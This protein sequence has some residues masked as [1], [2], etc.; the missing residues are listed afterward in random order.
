MTIHHI[1]IDSS[2]EVIFCY[3]YNSSDIE[4]MVSLME[5][6][7]LPISKINDAISTLMKMNTG[8]TI[9]RDDMKQSLVFVS[10]ATSIEQFSDT[11]AHEM[12]HVATAIIDYYNVYYDSEDAAW[13]HGYLTRMVTKRLKN[14][15]CLVLFK[16]FDN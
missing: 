14:N 6:F 3:G 1:D 15:F 12:N 4:A 7:G 11:I 2:W 8:M 16:S 9:S 5:Y 10:D 13:L